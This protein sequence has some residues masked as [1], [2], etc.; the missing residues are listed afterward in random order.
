M[1]WTF[2]GNTNSRKEK[3]RESA[4]NIDRKGTDG[5]KDA[6]RIRRKNPYNIKNESDDF[7]LNE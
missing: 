3:E 2:E 5:E 7:F 4:P 6:R 1:E